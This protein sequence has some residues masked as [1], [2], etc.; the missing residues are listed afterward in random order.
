MQN[1]ASTRFFPAIGKIGLTAI[2]INGLIGAGIFA[3]PG[4][5]N[6]LYGMLSPWLFVLCAILMLPIV[7]SFGKLA[8]QHSQTGGPITYASHSFGPWV[9]FQTGWLLYLGRLTALA[10]NGHALVLYLS[11]HLPILQTEWASKIAV[12]VLI[13]VLF[14]LNWLG[15]KR[16][17]G[18]MYLITALKL[19]PLLLLVLLGQAHLSG[20]LVAAL[21]S[22]FE[23]DIPTA[24]L[25]LIY[26]YL[27]FEGA[28]VPSEEAKAPK[29]DLPKALV[30][31]LLVSAVLYFFIQAV[32]VSTPLTEA[33]SSDVPLVAT[34]EQLF[35][36]QG[37]PFAAII[38]TLAAVVSIFGNL[39][40]L[41]LAAPRMTY[42]MAQNYTLPS[43]FGK[44]DKRFK[45]PHTSLIALALGGMVLAVTGT[46]VWLA[47]MSSVARLAGYLVC[48]LA[49]IKD[50]ST[51]YWRVIAGLGA[52]VCVW[53][54]AQATLSAYLMAFAFILLGSGL[55]WFSKRTSDDT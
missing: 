42:A 35:S 10:A 26:A 12:C 1:T 30:S 50:E 46:F 33:V 25:L 55:Y 39:M 54:L 48:M 49:L 36:E 18:A 9:G 32:V 24:M 51:L 34:L 19:L 6:E 43:W 45:T 16:A 40:A 3:L 53:L 27:G 20:D 14:L 21:P 47:I 28:L 52:L 13:G 2:A 29:Q 17:M 37:W 31:T 38:M 41:M 15:I 11:L 5:A 22:A 8:S 44:L 7:L 4:K 23:V